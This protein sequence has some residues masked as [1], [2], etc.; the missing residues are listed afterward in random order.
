MLDYSKQDTGEKLVMG[1]RHPGVS[2]MS[3]LLNYEQNK[4]L[5]VRIAT[6]R[7]GWTEAMGVVNAAR[8]NDRSKRSIRTDQH[9]KI[10]SIPM[11]VAGILSVSFVNAVLVGGKNLHVHGDYVQF[12]T[13]DLLHFFDM[14]Y[15]A[16]HRV[17]AAVT[18]RHPDI[19]NHGSFISGALAQTI[20][21]WED[22]DMEEIR[23]AQRDSVRELVEA[24]PEWGGW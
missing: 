8:I 14:A 11:T 17:G 12:S 19:I 10:H 5:T 20:Q 22:A 7:S 15:A 16:D 2:D 1:F 23:V 13:I 18:C 24:M 4:F 6:G 3:C 9:T 21:A